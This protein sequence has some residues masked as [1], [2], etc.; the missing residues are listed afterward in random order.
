[1]GGQ[2]AVNETFDDRDRHQKWAAPCVLAEPPPSLAQSLAQRGIW[3]ERGSWGE[4]KRKRRGRR[5][6]TSLHN[7][8]EPPPPLPPASTEAVEHRKL[9]FLRPQEHTPV[10]G[11]AGIARGGSRP[12]WWPARRAGGRAAPCAQCGERRQ[13][14]RGCAAVPEEGTI[15]A[16]PPR[17]RRPAVPPRAER[18]RERKGA[19][20]GLGAAEVEVEA[21]ARGLGRFRPLRRR[22]ETERPREGQRRRRYFWRRRGDWGR[23]VGKGRR[24]GA[25]AGA[26]QLG[27]SRAVEA[28]IKRTEKFW[29]SWTG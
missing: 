29:L 20:A 5:G 15:G 7:R 18:E 19:G 16:P 23:E 1:M 17:P 13:P 10:G 4:A 8:A 14:G 27:R 22:G 12:R 25:A 6:C 28:K 11:H 21:A 3:K 24:T 2:Y 9:G 26:Q